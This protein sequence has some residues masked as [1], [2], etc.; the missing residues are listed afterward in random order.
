MIKHANELRLWDVIEYVHGMPATDF[1]SVAALAQ[2]KFAVVTA[3]ERK[4]S[5]F[6]GPR[7]LITV[8]AYVPAAAG[9]CE[10]T[11]KADT[12]EFSVRDLFELRGVK[13]ALET[14]P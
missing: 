7:V 10:M 8:R 4:D 14:A 3:L 13:G 1:F 2:D 9:G 5:Q 12:R 6:S 11:S